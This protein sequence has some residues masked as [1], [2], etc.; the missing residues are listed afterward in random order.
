MNN[1]RA[2]RGNTKTIA[3]SKPTISLSEEIK[4]ELIKLKI[5]PRET[6][7]D[8]IKRILDEKENQND[9]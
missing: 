9:K 2:K 6:Y 4:L 1:N 8:I 7:Q 5:H 3:S